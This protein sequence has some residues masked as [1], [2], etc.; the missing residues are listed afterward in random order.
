VDAVADRVHDTLRVL[1]ADIDEISNRLSR[2]KATM[3][4]GVPAEQRKAR[5][6]QQRLR[7]LATL[8]CSI[9][10]HAR[11]R[12]HGGGRT[13]EEQAQ[14]I[15]E[16]STKFKDAKDVKWAGSLQLDAPRHEILLIE[17]AEVTVEGVGRWEPDPD[18]ASAVHYR[19]VPL[20]LVVRAPA[21]GPLRVTDKPKAPVPRPRAHKVARPTPTTSATRGRRWWCWTIIGAGVLAAVLYWLFG[22]S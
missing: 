1:D 6:A 20:R 2:L 14:L 3:R 4:S 21:D 7:Q 17:G 10:A 9:R 19:E 13:H 12:I 18:P 11:G 22:P 16:L 8:L 15:R 5:P